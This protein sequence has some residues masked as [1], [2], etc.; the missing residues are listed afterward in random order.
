MTTLYLAETDGSIEPI[1]AEALLEEM[2]ELAP[3]LDEIASAHEELVACR[4][5][6]G[7]ALFRLPKPAEYERFLGG[8]LSDRKEEKVKAGKILAGGTCVFPDRVTW[9]RMVSKYPGIPGA[10]VKPLNKL[11]GGELVERGKE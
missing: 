6:G 2:P 5:K 7:A 4:T 1:A 11:M 8:L 10:C 3:K 9:E